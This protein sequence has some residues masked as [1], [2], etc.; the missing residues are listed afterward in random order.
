MKRLLMA[1]FL[2]LPLLNGCAPTL[3]MEQYGKGMKEI[4]ESE[5][6]RQVAVLPF[7]NETDEQGLET[8]VRRNFAN[9][10]SS[11]S[12]QDVKLPIVDEKLVHFEKSSGKPATGATVPELAAAL[13]VDGL[14]FGKVTDYK[15]VYAGVYSQLR[16]EAEVWLVNAG[17]GQEIFRLRESVS[18]HEGGIPLSPLSVVVTV[19]STAINLRDIQKVRLVNELCY[20]FMGKIPSPATMASAAG[21]PVIREVLTNAVEGPFGPK[22]VIKVG[23]QGDPGLVATYDLG[24]FRK[25]LPM[26]ELQPGIY[27]GEYAVLPGDTTRDM[28]ITLTLTRPGGYETQWVDVSGFVAID[29][30]P[31]PQAAGL[32]AKGYADRVELTWNALR[33]VSDLKGYRVQRSESPLSGYTEL[34]MVELAAFS[35]KTAAAGKTYYY[36]ISSEDLAGNRAD[37]EDGVRAALAVVEPHRMAGT[38]QSDTTLDGVT[39]VTSTLVVPKGINLSIGSEGRLLFAAGAGLQVQGRLL[40]QGGETPVEFVPSGEGKWGGIVID[41]GAAELRRFTV[42]GATTGIDSRESEIFLENGIVSGCTTGIAISGITPAELKGLT[43]SGNT[44]GLKLSASAARITGSSFLQNGD[45]ILADGFSGEIRDNNLL[46]NERNISSVKPLSVGINWF[47]AI[48]SDE[49]RLVNVAAAKVYDAR[50]PGGN[51]VVPIVDPYAALSLEERQLKGAELLIEAGGYF[52]QRNFGKA[53]ALF[54]ENLQVLPTAETY[55][56]LGLCH[57]EMKEPEKAVTLLREGTAKFP[58]DAL[59]WKSL[60][61]LA[62]EKGDD[63]AAR[64]ALTEALRLSP[65]DKQARFVLDRLKK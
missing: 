13:G 60:G 15:K 31:P 53:A 11:K 17:T 8:V 23:L 3:K 20:K 2:V 38:L 45:G 36:R 59:L 46:D 44:A 27:A 51:T 26:T 58:Q 47:G 22:R 42:R 64:E 55:F 32:R 18:Y 24:S 34:A 25:G 6:P 29:T 14:L 63:A 9:H 37:A 21:R 54:S 62:Y 12:F 39:Q 7:I 10:L 28:P 4:S 40:V 50:F 61:M 35:D 52:R 19:V 1:C 16:V 65:D 48:R 49:L 43:V 57:Q 30:T 33:N 41:G 5:L 56:Y